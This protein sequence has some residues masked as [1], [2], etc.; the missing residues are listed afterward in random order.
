MGKIEFVLAEFQ[1]QLYLYTYDKDNHRKG[2]KERAKK[3][4]EKKRSKK[5]IIL[6]EEIQKIVNEV[7]DIKD[8]IKE[9]KG[10]LSKPEI[11]ELRSKI[12][13]LKSIKKTEQKKF[14]HEMKEERR[15]FKLEA[16]N[17]RDINNQ[18]HKEEKQKV[19]D[20]ERKQRGEK[21]YED[22][23]FF[24]E[25][26]REPQIIK[27]VIK[28][29]KKDLRKAQKSDNQEAIEFCKNKLLEYENSLDTEID[30]VISLTYERYNKSG[31]TDN[32]LDLH[33]LKK[34]E[35]LRLLDKIIAVKIQQI[36]EKFGEKDSREPFEYNIVTGRGN[37]TG[38]SVLKPAV[39]AYLIDN[40]IKY[41]EF[42]NQAGYTALL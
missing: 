19:R 4:K 36:N 41:I 35:A 18:E 13:E 2:R 21:D 27:Q 34:A 31:Q 25:I 23:V 16:K 29:T 5:E 15:R 8:K 24:R 42:S 30:K 32:R 7:A 22:D 11:K 37:H 40:G 28:Q 17:L 9:G 10:T 38:R 33:G 39:K 1:K 6:P 26:R 3:Y 14:K 12:K 20:E